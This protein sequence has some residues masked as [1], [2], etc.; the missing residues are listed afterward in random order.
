[1]G[2]SSKRCLNDAGSDVMVVVV[3]KEVG[4]ALV[5]SR[6]TPCTCLCAECALLPDRHHEQ[7]QWQQVLYSSQL[8]WQISLVYSAEQRDKA[9]FFRR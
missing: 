4:D 9:R 6:N 3:G 5:A 8:V 2:A 1:M 7:W